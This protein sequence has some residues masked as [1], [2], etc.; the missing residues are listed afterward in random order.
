MIHEALQADLAKSF[1]LSHAGHQKT[2]ANV[3]HKE[4]VEKAKAPGVG[5]ELT[6]R[7]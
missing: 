3:G 2:P 1:V 4:T 5:M 6:A 7:Q